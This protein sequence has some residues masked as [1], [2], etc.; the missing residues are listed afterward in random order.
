MTRTKRDMMSRKARKLA[1]KLIIVASNKGGQGKSLVSQL[2]ADHAF[3]HGTPLGVAQIDNQARLA[4]S[5]GRQV[6]TIDSL[7]GSARRD[8]GAEARAF[9]PLYAMIEKAA[10]RQANVLID[11]GANQAGRFI[12][13]AGLVDL[14]EDLATWGFEA[15]AMTPF[16][17]EAEGIRQG[18]RTA[19]AMLECFPDARLVLIENERDGLVADLHPASDAA[20]A[21]REVIEPLKN[22][23]SVLRMPAVEAGSWRLFEGAHCRPV[24]VAGMAIEKVMSITGLPRPEA[25][26]ARG[27]VAAFA[28]IVFAELDRVLLWQNREDGDV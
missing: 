10:Q 17:A 11:V 13:W 20:A 14:P 25:K 4:R 24:Q 3:L 16:V 18:G 7:P 15:I 19:A 1:L 6:L 12:A 23:A 26:I 27:D 8:P 2:T 22:R 21:Y 28:G 5:L 9:T